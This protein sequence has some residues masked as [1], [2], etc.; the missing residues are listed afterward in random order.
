MIFAPHLAVNLRGPASRNLDG[1]ARQIQSLLRA[2]DAA[3]CGEE[4]ARTKKDSNAD[5]QRMHNYP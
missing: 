2:H 5:E 1:I 3:T 4:Q